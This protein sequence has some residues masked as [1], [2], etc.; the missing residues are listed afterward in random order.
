[1]DKLSADAHV[2][3]GDSMAAQNRPRTPDE[4]REAL[5]EKLAPSLGL[6]YTMT[7]PCDQCPFLIESCFDF[8]SLEAH[9]SGSFA[10]HKQCE[11]NDEGVFEAR[12]PK[13]QHCA[14]ALI[15]LEKQNGPHQMM[16]IAERLG[17]YDRAKLDMEAP[18]VGCE[19]DTFGG[20]ENCRIK[21]Q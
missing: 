1:V 6:Q 4:A 10:C 14:G 11:L 9:A 3:P 19:A 2:W 5:F 13:T 21:Q 17:H 8:E 16:R 20:I 15:F 18:V 7:T 12:G